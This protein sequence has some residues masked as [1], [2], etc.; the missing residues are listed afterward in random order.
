MRAYYILT[1]FRSETAREINT[2]P[3]DI[4]RTPPVQ[5]ALKVPHTR[6][7]ARSPQ[8]WIDV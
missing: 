2:L 5:S 7:L 6:S 4:L 3:P 1:H 8:S